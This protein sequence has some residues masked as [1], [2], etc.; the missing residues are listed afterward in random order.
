MKKIIIKYIS[1][2]NTLYLT[3]AL[4]GLTQMIAEEDHCR[5]YFNTVFNLEV[6]NSGFYYYGTYIYFSKIGQGYNLY[7]QILNSLA[8][9]IIDPLVPSAILDFTWDPDVSFN[10][11]NMLGTI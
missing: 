7:S 3:F 10:Y 9:V 5:L 8:E 1:G 4:D 11:S 6:L 2:G